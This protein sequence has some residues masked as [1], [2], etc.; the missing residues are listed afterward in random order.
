MHQ[1][2]YCD[3]FFNLCLGYYQINLD[4]DLLVNLRIV[5]FNLVSKIV[6]FIQVHHF[7]LLKSLTKVT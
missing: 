5:D 6:G 4:F 3:L 7:W 2:S 1:G